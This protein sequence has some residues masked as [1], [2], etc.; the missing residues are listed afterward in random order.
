[1]AENRL[2]FHEKKCSH[3]QGRHGSFR[4]LERNKRGPKF[5]GKSWKS[6]R[7]KEGGKGGKGVG[8]ILP[9]AW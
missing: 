1:M 6:R 7:W 8:G 9:R 5:C 3:F 4:L 2:L